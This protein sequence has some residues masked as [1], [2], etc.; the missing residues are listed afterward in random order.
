MYATRRQRREQPVQVG[1]GEDP[2]CEIADLK[3]PAVSMLPSCAAALKLKSA[4]A[5]R[6]TAAAVMGRDDTAMARLAHA[7][8]FGAEAPFRQ[9][10]LD[11]LRR[12]METAPDDYR[13]ADLH[14]RFEQQAILLD[15]CVL[16]ARAETLAGVVIEFILPALAGL[17]V[18]SRV[19]PRP[20]ETIAAA[21]KYPEVHRDPDCFRIR[22]CL[23]VLSPGCV[24]RA[25][26]TPLRLA[27]DRK[28][29]GQKIAIR[30]SLVAQGLDPPRAGRLRVRFRG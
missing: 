3:I 8:I 18:A 11:T 6:K 21:Q 10:G 26:A 17:E 27:V 30:Y 24:A 16:N 15:F 9:H 25:F 5:A 13:E 12:A 14:H 20:G 28:L 23:G 2:C 22:S 7:R 29:I 1:I 19:Y 4:I